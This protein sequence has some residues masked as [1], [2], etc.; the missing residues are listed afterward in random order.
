MSSYGMS[1]GREGKATRRV[2][3][4]CLIGTKGKEEEEK[5]NTAIRTRPKG[6]IHLEKR[7]K[8]DTQV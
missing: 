5:K 7:K 6:K 3:I 1:S 4:D 8:K 2:E